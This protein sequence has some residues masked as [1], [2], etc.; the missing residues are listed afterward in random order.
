[1]SLQLHSFPELVRSHLDLSYLAE[2]RDPDGTPIRTIYGYIGP[3][4]H[5]WFGQTPDVVR[6]ALTMEHIKSG[7]KRISDEK[8]YPPVTDGIQTLHVDEHSR[9][10]LFIKGPH[11]S[12]LDNEYG[13]ALIPEMLLHEARI[14]EFLEAH[15]HAKIAKYHGCTVR[16]GY[17]TGIALERYP[18]PLQHAFYGDQDHI[19]ALL[20]VDHIMSEI[21]SAVG[22]LHGLGYAHNDI[23]PTNLALDKDNEV[24]VLDL[25][26]C[27]K[28]GETMVSA[29]TNGWSI[30]FDEEGW[31]VS[32]AK[33][34][35]RGISRVEAWLREKVEER[36][37]AMAQ[38]GDGVSG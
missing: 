34:D 27:R 24:V 16:R 6:Y 1:M 21:R 35:E 33:H 15:P 14:Y 30:D 36:R 18:L 9:E 20:D 11:M 5:V 17:I 3:E 32:S 25:G 2:V 37:R 7:L 29:G 38:D 10:G 8:V 12:G 19:V 4:Q 22:H 28:I 26:S 23:N 13:A 31:D